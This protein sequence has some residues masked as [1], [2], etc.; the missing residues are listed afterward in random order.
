M[1]NFFTSK[2]KMPKMIIITTLPDDRKDMKVARAIES[3]KKI[4][5]SWKESGT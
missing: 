2:T 4:R 3:P 1:P 5:E